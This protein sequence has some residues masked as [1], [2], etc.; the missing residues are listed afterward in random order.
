MQARL[1]D[2]TQVWKPT[3]ARKHKQKAPYLWEIRRPLGVNQASE[4]LA[5]LLLSSS[6][7][8]PELTTGGVIISDPPFSYPRVL[9]F[10]TFF[11]DVF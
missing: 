10:R 3:R 6:L 1:A 8:L 9:P 4:I 11:G 2:M 7:D 5:L